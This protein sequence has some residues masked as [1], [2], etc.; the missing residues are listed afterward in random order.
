MQRPP[1]HT[2]HAPEVVAEDHAVPRLD[3][4]LLHERPGH[5]ARRLPR[6]P[7]RPVARLAVPGL[8]PGGEHLVPHGLHRLGHARHDVG[9]GRPDLRVV[10]VPQVRLRRHLEALVQDLGRVLSNAW[11]V[12]GR[13]VEDGVSTAL[14]VFLLSNQWPT[15][16]SPST[17]RPTQRSFVSPLTMSNMSP[18]SWIR[19]MTS[20]SIP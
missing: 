8:H 7:E 9:H 2:R 10:R 3:A 19:V 20:S 12:V 15:P 5:R 16:L 6:L 13:S 17:T 1:W 14:P 11:G 4:P 18:Q